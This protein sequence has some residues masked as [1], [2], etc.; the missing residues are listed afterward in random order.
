[1]YCYHI[2]YVVQNWSLVYILDRIVDDMDE[3]TNKLISHH[4]YC[5]QVKVDDLCR[6]LKF[7]HVFV[8]Y[9]TRSI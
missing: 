6:R 5:T 4:N 2:K 9:S 1:M 3:P 8:F 7:S